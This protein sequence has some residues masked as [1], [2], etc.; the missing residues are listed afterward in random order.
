M[1]GRAAA[2][3]RMAAR[4]RRNTKRQNRGPQRAPRRRISAKRVAHLPPSSNP[5]CSALFGFHRPGLAPADL[6]QS[7]VPTKPNNEE[8]DS[9]PRPSPGRRIRE[10]TPCHAAI[11]SQQ[12]RRCTPVMAK[13]SRHIPP[14]PHRRVQAAPGGNC[15]VVVRA[16]RASF[17]AT[18]RTRPKRGNR[19][20][21]RCGRGRFFGDF[22]VATRKSLARRGETR[23]ITINRRHT[24]NRTTKSN[25]LNP[26][27]CRGDES[28]SLRPLTQSSHRSSWSASPPC[29]EHSP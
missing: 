27:V 29:P 10:H 22:L 1:R 2:R 25:T 15:R 5:A 13:P 12:C 26:G 20:S 8:R 21:R 28:A 3:W 4:P 24:P 9:G 23:P 19:R 6:H 17:D 7:T 11:S 16:R 14:L 18:R